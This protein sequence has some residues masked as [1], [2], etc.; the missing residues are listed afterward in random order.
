VTSP[1]ED[2]ARIRARSGD[3]K[4][5]VAGRLGA[6]LD[7]AVDADAEGGDVTAGEVDAAVGLAQLSGRRPRRR[8]VL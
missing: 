7:G 5:D 1:L 8:P 6:R 2:L 4:E 3:R